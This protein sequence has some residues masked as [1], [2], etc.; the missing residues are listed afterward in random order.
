M[1]LWGRCT[2]SAGSSIRN[3]F[4]LG[5]PMVAISRRTTSSKDCC[6]TTL[7]LRTGISIVGH[8]RLQFSPY[9]TGMSR[10]FARRSTADVACGAR[11]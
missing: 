9:A 7:N 10:S 4:R 5:R 3:A 8:I 2:P 1:E 6:E 11:S